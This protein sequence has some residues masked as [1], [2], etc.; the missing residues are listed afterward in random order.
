MLFDHS[1]SFGT[2]IRRR[3]NSHSQEFYLFTIRRAGCK[4]QVVNADL[5]IPLA[6]QEGGIQWSAVIQVAHSILLKWSFAP[7]LSDSVAKEGAAVAA[8]L[9]RGLEAG[10]VWIM[11]E[12]DILDRSYTFTPFQAFGDLSEANDNVFT[13]DTQGPEIKVV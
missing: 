5:T 2:A 10:K 4:A 7:I 6:S 9:G 12:A 3:A 1:E 13:V 8:L 11:I